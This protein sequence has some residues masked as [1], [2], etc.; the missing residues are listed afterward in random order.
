MLARLLGLFVAAL[1]LCLPALAGDVRFSG[2]V[3]YRER[4]ALPADTELW[5]TLVTLPEGAPVVSAAAH[6][7]HPA[8]V[9]LSFMLD[10]HSHVAS[11]GGSFGLVAEIRS[12]GL[13]I[14]R[15]P[16]PV[17]VDPAAP[18]PVSILVHPVPRPAPMP[19]PDPMPDEEAMLP[20]ADALAPLLDTVWT[21]TSI[22]GD[23]VL[24]A[25][26]PTLSIAA[27]RRAGGNGSCNNYFTEAMFEEAALAF[28]P[29]AGTRMA[30]SAEVMA[31][32][33]RLFAALSATAAYRLEGDALQLVDAAGVPLVGLVRKP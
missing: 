31:Q 27:D 5:V 28:G 20:P 32:E 14:F 26:E 3:T 10:V 9:P 33:A 13:P 12:G 8:Q 17:P 6:V 16:D 15:N 30:C 19:E 29:I 18:A 4:M 21:V 22:G 23:P 11:S 2:E 1:S 24:A 7:S 25:T